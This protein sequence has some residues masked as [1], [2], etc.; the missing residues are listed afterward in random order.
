MKVNDL[1][2]RPMIRNQTQ[3]D[4]GQFTLRLTKN[5]EHFYWY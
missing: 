3:S 1:I 2:E 5:E 4:K